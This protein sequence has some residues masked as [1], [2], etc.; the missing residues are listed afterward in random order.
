MLVVSAMARLASSHNKMFRQSAAAYLKPPSHAAVLPT[1]GAGYR[2]PVYPY[3]AQLGHSGSYLDIDQ[4]L[5]S[6]EEGIP[7]RP[8]V[9]IVRTS[10]SS[11]G[12]PG[13]INSLN[14]WLCKFVPYQYFQI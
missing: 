7:Y 1:Y 10:G 4:G 12:S 13:K 6:L 3:P 5:Q 8:V 2:N 9:R 14:A 11:A